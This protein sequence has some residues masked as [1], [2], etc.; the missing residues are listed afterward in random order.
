MATAEPLTDGTGLSSA[1]PAPP[2]RASLA[3]G[4]LRQGCS[5]GWMWTALAM[6]DIRLRYRGSALG[7][8]WLTISTL[9]MSVAMGGIYPHLFGTNAANYVPYLVTGLVL[10]QFVSTTI[11]EG[12]GTFVAM[13][14]VIH[15]TPMPFSVHAFRVVYR[16]LIV[17]AHNAILVPFALLLFHVPVDARILLAAPALVLLSLNAVWVSLFLGI[18]SARFRDVPPIVASFLQVVFFV[19]PVFWAP[20]ALGRWKIFADLNPLFAAVDIVR[21]PL[22]GVPTQPWSW[23]VMLAATL[24]GGGG[25]FVFFARFRS[26]IAYWL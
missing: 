21:A 4:D 11:A 10:W 17:L 18:V 25:A 13:E 23:W 26:R 24:L 12:C 6:Q 9:I 15:Q 1:W 5:S 20:D 2:S 3:L 16:N 22:L 7:P 14:S 19:T 8:F